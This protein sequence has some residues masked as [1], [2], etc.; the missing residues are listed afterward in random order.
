MNLKTGEFMSQFLES[1][2]V[3]HGN[4]KNKTKTVIRRSKLSQIQRKF[5]ELVILKTY[6]FGGDGPTEYVS[7]RLLC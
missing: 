3:P 6:F 7:T 4:Q 1:K 2:T 5:K